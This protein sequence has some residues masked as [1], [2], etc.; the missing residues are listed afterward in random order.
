MQKKI[1]ALAVAGLVSGAAFA[2]TSVTFGGIVDVAYQYSGSHTTDGIKSKNAID[3]GGQD[4]SRLFWEAKEDLGN[5]LS[6][7]AYQQLRMAA[8]D[9]SA[10]VANKSI[11]TLS[12]K[13]W[14]AIRA[15]NYG[16]V[17]DDINGF[18][19]VGGMGW[20][21]GV[22]DMITN[23]TNYNVVGYVTP[24]F[25]GFT[26]KLNLA[27]HDRAQADRD[28]NGESNVRM[29]GVLGAYVGNGLKL[30]ASYQKRSGASLGLATTTTT[31]DSTTVG[32]NPVVTT[33]TYGPVAKQVEW[34]LS[35]GYT[36]GQFSI[37]AGY[38]REKTYDVSVRKAYR[39][40][41]GFAI[42]PTDQVNLSYMRVKLDKDAGT[43]TKLSGVGL[44]YSHVLSKRTNVYA[45]Y[46]KI[47]QDVD[48]AILAQYE[49]RFKV[50]LRHQF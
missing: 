18:S 9:R 46:A 42:T 12:G 33:T 41:A 17:S 13:S 45:S 6:V 16:S 25:N 27:S 38:D 19:E 48:T 24:D 3:N 7:S 50:G 49:S 43:D 40:N 39:I 14:G 21:N 31:V 35:G 15:G 47:S 22:V 1:I 32:V 34:M 2:Q 8:D 5:G 30:G 29:V 44:S 10:P 28:G 23:G 26:A 37:G 11:L 4:S 36:M 20:G